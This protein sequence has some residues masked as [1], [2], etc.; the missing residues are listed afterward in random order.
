VRDKLDLGFVHFLRWI[1]G[2]ERLGLSEFENEG[3]IFFFKG[4]E[5]DYE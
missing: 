3:C 2:R 1:R 5:G 4:F